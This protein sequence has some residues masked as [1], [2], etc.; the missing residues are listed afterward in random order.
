M[1]VSSEGP[2]QVSVLLHRLHD[3]R[4]D[5]AES[6][7]IIH[8]I[9]PHVSKLEGQE[10]Q[11][12]IDVLDG[13]ISVPVDPKF[14]RECVH[15][16]RKISGHTGM[17]PASYV[18]VEGLTKQ[19][20][21]PAASGGFADVWVGSYSEGVV[22]IK[23]L[24]VYRGD[25]QE[26]LKKIFCKE[27]VVWKR[28]SHPNI[29][30]LIGVSNTLF[31]FCMV[32][33]WMENGNVMEYLRSNPGTDRVQLLTDIGNGLK[34]LHSFAIVHGDLKGANVLINESRQACLAD[35]GLTSI[36][37]N[38]N[39]LNA[40]TL[41]SHR[42]GT[43]RWMAPEILDPEVFGLPTSS[44][45]ESSTASD[46]YSFAMVV[47]EIFTGNRPFQEFPHDPTVIVKVMRGGRPIRPKQL[48]DRLWE[49]VEMCWRQDG[50][51]RPPISE[52][53]DF[54]EK[55][56]H[57]GSAP[58]LAVEGTIHLGRSSTE[59]LNPSAALPSSTT[60]VSHRSEPYGGTSS[61]ACREGDSGVPSSFEENT[62]PILDDRER[63]RFALPRRL[64]RVLFPFY[65]W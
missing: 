40:S 19:G 12:V 38:F 48:S 6:L 15:A 3:N 61:L 35:F 57:G 36:L 49:L 29:L 11:D 14:F 5:S 52:V 10:A 21:V 9:L 30:P 18:L 23:S 26:M 31:P 55:I 37:S 58:S 63:I 41:A 47:M 44:N 50:T 24:R 7:G 42:S 17:L 65:P 22:A 28:L 59:H 43:V 53:L 34:Y 1:D 54:L 13:A 45:R 51:Q 56:P 64:L 20:N 46:V 16:L 4:L 25:D 33:P 32:S 62:G 2:H 27:V 60:D 39:S 8:S